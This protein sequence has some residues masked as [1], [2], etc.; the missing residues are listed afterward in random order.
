LII[1]LP[2]WIAVVSWFPGFSIGNLISGVAIWVALGMLASQVGR[3]QGKKKEA[4]L[5]Q[6]WGG[7]P[8]TYMLRH[9]DPRLNSV[10]R[11]RYHAKLGELLPS[12]R[13]PTAEEEAASPAAA[14][15]EYESCVHYLREKT[16]DRKRF[17][18]LFSENVGYGFRRNLWA[19]RGGGVAL[20]M[21]AILA[22]VARLGLEW[23]SERKVSPGPMIGLLLNALLTALWLVRFNSGWVR[24]AAEGY[25]RALLA[26]CEELAAA[27]NPKT[28][29]EHG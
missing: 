7:A 12:L 5:F 22:C 19:M 27:E 15:E 2:V 9:S 25:G 3:D 14:D 13:M 6:K 11:R 23:W 8:A 1:F 29:G 4:M 26:A 16:R 18:L 24:I 17:E 28:G 20:G 10:T 21:I